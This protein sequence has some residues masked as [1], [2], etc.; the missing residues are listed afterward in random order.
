MNSSSSIPALRL[1]GREDSR[2][3]AW[4]PSATASLCGDGTSSSISKSASSDALSSLESSV[5]AKS[6]APLISFA[7][8]F[9]CGDGDDES[10]APAG[11]C[12]S[13]RSL[14]LSGS[15]GMFARVESAIGEACPLTGLGSGEEDIVVV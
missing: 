6:W 10:R 8:S 14:S 2:E 13:D 7:S 12:T 9:G 11:S 15:S 5:S 4:A 3:L 1:G